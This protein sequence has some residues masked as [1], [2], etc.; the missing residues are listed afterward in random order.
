MRLIYDWC[1]LTGLSAHELITFYLTGCQ[2]R[3]IWAET[4]S[5]GISQRVCCW[6][7]EDLDSRLIFTCTCIFKGARSQ[8]QNSDG[9]QHWDGSQEIKSSDGSDCQ[10]KLLEDDINR[11]SV[12]IWTKPSP[13]PAPP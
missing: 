10:Q 13:P 3:Q 1:L 4:Q 9:P 5:D 8:D 11:I 6:G 7:R 12:L 2:W